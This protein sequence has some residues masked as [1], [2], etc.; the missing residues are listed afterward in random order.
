MCAENVSSFTTDDATAVTPPQTADKGQVAA[1]MHPWCS[2]L[3][4]CLY[5]VWRK[6]ST[7]LIVSFIEPSQDRIDSRVLRLLW[8]KRFALIE[9]QSAACF[10]NTGF[11]IALSTGVSVTIKVRT[12]SP[13]R[14]L[15][16][17][18]FQ[19]LLLLQLLRF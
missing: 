14:A 10:A 1:R 18:A 2:H 11:Y 6:A 15:G 12:G 5:K 8:R 3:S 7:F 9:A 19:Q 17:K 4:P 13:T 16:V